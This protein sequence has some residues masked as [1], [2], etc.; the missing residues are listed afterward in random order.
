M[1]RLRGQTKTDAAGCH[2][3]EFAA[4]GQ[5]SQERWA[6][7]AWRGRE[8][9]ERPG[10]GGVGGDGDDGGGVSEG[11]AR[12]PLCADESGQAGLCLGR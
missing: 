1:K 5:G 6:T 8:R 7:K 9:R 3:A 10:I 12:V 11:G 2:P 4:A